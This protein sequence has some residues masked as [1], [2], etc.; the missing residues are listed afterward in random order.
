[1]KPESDH[2][3]AA[4]IIL[5]VLIMTLITCFVLLD[6]TGEKSSA[7]PKTTKTDGIKKF[8]ELAEIPATS[9]KIDHADCQYPERWSNP[10]NGCDNTDPAV[11]DCIDQMHSQ[12]AEQTCIKNYSQ[13][14]TDFEATLKICAQAL[15]DMELVRRS[16][17][18]AMRNYESAYILNEQPYS[19]Q[20]WQFGVDNERVGDA[21]LEKQWKIFTDHCDKYVTNRRPNSFG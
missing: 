3:K 6:K 11:P 2:I 10:E 4:L 18:D 5:L 1:M 13:Q 7:K 20:A 16:Y 14:H 17:F 19:E 8:K 15:Y 9:A 12:E 21:E